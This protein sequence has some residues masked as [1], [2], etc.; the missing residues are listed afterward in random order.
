MKIASLTPAAQLIRMLLKIVLIS[1][2]L[3]KAA[4]ASGRTENPEIKVSFSVEKIW[5]S[6]AK[7]DECSTCTCDDD[8][9]WKAGVQGYYTGCRKVT[10]N[11]RGPTYDLADNVMFSLENYL[12]KLMYFANTNST[13]LAP[14]AKTILETMGKMKNL[15]DSSLVIISEFDKVIS[16]IIR[17][18]R[19]VVLKLSKL[20]GKLVFKF[21]NGLLRLYYIF[22]N[23][24][25]CF[26]RCKTV[27][28][29]QKVDYIPLFRI[30]IRD[31]YQ[32]NQTTWIKV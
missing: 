23:F 22:S 2:A 18:L 12:T 19:E 5:Q 8:D 30:E 26:L 15:K 6:F 16:A 9:E 7:K 17:E 32:P 3:L 13:V 10:W 21:H 1:I 27:Q 11:F 14:N 29:K 31:G 28:C 4:D 24:M 20:I 25:K